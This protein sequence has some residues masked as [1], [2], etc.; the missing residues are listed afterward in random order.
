[1]TR[2]SHTYFFRMVLFAFTP[3]SG[4]SGPGLFIP[5]VRNMC[6]CNFKSEPCGF[7]TQYEVLGSPCSDLQVVF[8]YHCRMV[9][10][11]PRLLGVDPYL[12]VTLWPIFSS[13]GWDDANI[14]T[15]I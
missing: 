8:S 13:K 7:D 9:V 10:W 11:I 15:Q 5:G 2:K 6:A 1:M 12:D 4:S 3:E 14:V